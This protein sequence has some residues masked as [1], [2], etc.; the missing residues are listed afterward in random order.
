MEAVKQFGFTSSADAVGE[1][2]QTGNP[3]TPN[4]KEFKIIGVVA[5]S[6]FRNLRT[7][8]GPELY[9]LSPEM[10]HFLT[11][12][13]RGDYQSMIKKIRG[14]W[15]NVVGDFLFKDSNVKQNLIASFSQE[16]RENTAFIA[17]ALLSVSF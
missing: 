16:K 1:I 8:P 12:R 2:L 6:Q 13:Y 4:Y 5:D 9:Q 14:I 15:N 11:V 3:E 10:T 17:F 7:K